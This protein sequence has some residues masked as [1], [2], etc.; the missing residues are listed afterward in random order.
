MSPIR[1]VMLTRKYAQELRFLIFMSDNKYYVKASGYA[2]WRKSHIWLSAHVRGVGGK[3][4]VA[5]DNCKVSPDRL[6]WAIGFLCLFL[7]Q[8]SRGAYGR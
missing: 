4:T 8:F 1:F 5:A 7:N 2:L 3:S 6:A